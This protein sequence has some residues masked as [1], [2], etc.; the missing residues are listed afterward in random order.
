VPPQKDG[1]I[2]FT[3]VLDSPKFRHSTAGPFTIYALASDPDVAATLVAD[4]RVGLAPLKTI[5]GP[6]RAR[7]GRESRA[8][9][10]EA[11][12]RTA[13]HAEGGTGIR[14]S[15][16][17]HRPGDDEPR[18]TS[19]SGLLDHCEDLGFSK[20]KPVNQLWTPECRDA[21]VARTWE[22]QVFNLQHPA[23]SERSEAWLEHGSA[24]TRWRIS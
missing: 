9:A 24:T 15:E 1:R 21:E 17:D 14:V 7:S 18:T 12:R 6:A 5:P 23:I 11:R 3:T 16:P 19:A 8:R 13:S 2:L 10:Y 4:A 20:W 22:V